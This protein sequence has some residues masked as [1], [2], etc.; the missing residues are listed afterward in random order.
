MLFIILK[1]L[2]FGSSLKASRM[3]P[4]VFFKLALT[5]GFE[6][7]AT[8]RI[9]VVQIELTDLGWFGIGTDRQKFVDQAYMFYVYP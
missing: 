7:F 6:Q 3:G 5:L 1:N 2:S 4:A 8:L 9:F